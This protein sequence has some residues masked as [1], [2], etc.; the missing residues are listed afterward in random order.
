MLFRID[1]EL[2]PGHRL[3][4]ERKTQPLLLQNANL[5]VLPACSVPDSAPKA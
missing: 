1:R 3:F 4:S 5:A 2:M